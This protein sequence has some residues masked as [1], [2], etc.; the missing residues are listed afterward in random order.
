MKLL[1][2]PQLEDMV[3]HGCSVPGCTH[4][5]HQQVF[6]HPKCHPSAGLSV[7]Y[8]RGSGKLNILCRE[9]KQPIVDVSVSLV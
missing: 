2:I 4:A 5:D 6:I 1:A 3:A 8:E 9:C 7:R